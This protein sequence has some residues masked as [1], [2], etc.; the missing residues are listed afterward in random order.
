MQWG[1]MCWLVGFT[2]EV[3]AD[4]QK[5]Q[6]RADPRNEGSVIITRGCGRG[7]VTLTILAKFCCGSGIAVMAVPYLSGA[8]SGL[9][10]CHPYSCMDC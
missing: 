4:R 5:S 2:V 7:R 1:A 10:Y 8:P 6:F 3:V 9:S